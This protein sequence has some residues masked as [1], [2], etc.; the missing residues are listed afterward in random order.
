MALLTLDSI[1]HECL[2]LLN[3]SVG[4]KKVSFR[5]ELW[6]PQGSVDEWYHVSDGR[7]RIGILVWIK[8]NDF[9]I[10]SHYTR[11]AMCGWIEAGVVAYDSLVGKIP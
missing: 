5:F 6:R 3:D 2:I 1:A 11:D 10:S 4:G 9:Y 8:G 7:C